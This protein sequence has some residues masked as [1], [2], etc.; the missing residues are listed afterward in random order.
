MPAMIMLVRMIMLMRMT[1]MKVKLTM[2]TFHPQLVTSF[3]STIA[4]SALEVTILIY[5]DTNY[6]P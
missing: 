4:Y 5:L 3:V 6:N 2:V 1:V